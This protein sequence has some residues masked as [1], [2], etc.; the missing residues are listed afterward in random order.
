MTQ[1]PLAV[2]PGMPAELRT[3]LAHLTGRIRQNG[4]LF[5]PKSVQLLANALIILEAAPAI[6]ENMGKAI[7]EFCLKNVNFTP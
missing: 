6:R 4:F 3:R 7:H 2:S 1:N 5:D